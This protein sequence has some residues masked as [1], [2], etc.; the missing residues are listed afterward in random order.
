MSAIDD[1]RRVA[2]RVANA[3]TL[4]TQTPED[5]ATDLVRQVRDARARAETA[6]TE[7]DALKAQ[8]AE[9]VGV[10]QSVTGA[11][12]SSFPGDETVGWPE[13][14]EVSMTEAWE[15]RLVARAFLA[16]AKP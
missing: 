10:L 8:L 16:K 7:R 2:M 13:F 12:E 4:E 9:A 6:E 5:M 15:R 11:L 14:P 3:L 1:A